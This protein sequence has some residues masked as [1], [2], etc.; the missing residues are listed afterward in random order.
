MSYYIFQKAM[1][2]PNK[3]QRLYKYTPAT[4]F[5]SQQ[6]IAA[7]LT[8]Q[9]QRAHLSITGCHRHPQN[10]ASWKK[11]SSKQDLLKHLMI[12]TYYFSFWW[13]QVNVTSDKKCVCYS[14]KVYSYPNYLK[15]LSS[16]L[17]VPNELNKFPLN[18]FYNK[19]IINL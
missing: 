1:P 17:L 4:N 6:E 10:K 8:Y 11:S 2:Q 19:K 16:H 3:L 13:S 18:A 14:D 9:L 5:I 15:E 12:K 7:G